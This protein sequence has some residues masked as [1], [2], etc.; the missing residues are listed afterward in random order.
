MLFCGSSYF[1]CANGLHRTSYV[2]M[3]SGSSNLTCDLQRGLRLQALAIRLEAIASRLEV[4]AVRLE[5]IALRLEVVTVD[6]RP[7]L[8]D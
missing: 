8:L 7:S 5:A 6:W 1:T 3:D 4:I 2:Q